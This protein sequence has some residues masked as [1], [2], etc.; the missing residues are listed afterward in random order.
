[1]RE[2]LWA[3][4]DKFSNSISHIMGFPVHVMATE[5]DDKKVNANNNARREKK[6]NATGKNKNEQKMNELMTQDGSKNRIEKKISFM[7]ENK[8]KL[9][10]PVN[11]YYDSM[12]EVLLLCHYSGEKKISLSFLRLK[13]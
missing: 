13:N 8:V 10:S 12:T 11:F 9:S 4:I 6:L 7:K 3:K 2:K 5:S 1:M